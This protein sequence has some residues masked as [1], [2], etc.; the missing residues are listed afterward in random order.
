MTPPAK[1]SLQRS[2]GKP[3]IGQQPSLTTDSFTVN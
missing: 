3:G 1:V 2:K